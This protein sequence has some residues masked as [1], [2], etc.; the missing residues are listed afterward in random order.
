V[1]FSSVLAGHHIALY[2]LHTAEVTGSIPVP[3]TLLEVQV[4]ACF[5]ALVFY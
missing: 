4:R 1:A 2:C 5:C 3:P